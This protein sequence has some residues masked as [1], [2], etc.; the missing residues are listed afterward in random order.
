MKTPPEFYQAVKSTIDHLGV[1]I[2]SE[3]GAADPEIIINAMTLDA[4]TG[5]TEKLKSSEPAI[6]WALESFSPSPVDPLYELVFTIGP[7][8]TSDVSA[9]LITGLVGAVQSKISEISRF[10]IKNYAGEE[11]SEL[12]GETGTGHIFS[13]QVQ[14][15]MFDNQSAI[16]LVRV[17]AHVVRDK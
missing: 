8:T 5:V 13:T 9:E 15:Q 17:F 11:V 3:V 14:E 1:G 12:P 4:T 16:R 10:D 6:V 7:K 2:A